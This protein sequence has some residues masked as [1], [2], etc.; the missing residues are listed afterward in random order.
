[1][2][3]I[4]LNLIC[5]LGIIFLIYLLIYSITNLSI[6]LTIFTI[7]GFIYFSSLSFYLTLHIIRPLFTY[8]YIFEDGIKIRRKDS[9][10]VNL[11]R[12]FCL[13]SEITYIKILKLTEFRKKGYFLQITFLNGISRKLNKYEVREPEEVFNIIAPKIKNNLNRS[14]RLDLEVFSEKSLDVY[15]PTLEFVEPYLQTDERI[16][17]DQIKLVNLTVSRILV[18]SITILLI[19]LMGFLYLITIFID[20]DQIIIIS[21]IITL[22][23]TGMFIIITFYSRKILVSRKQ[24]LHLTGAE[25]KNIVHFDTIANQRYIRRNFYSDIELYNENFHIQGLVTKDHLL[26]IPF[27][28]VERVIIDDFYHRIVFI[29]KHIKNDIEMDVQNVQNDFEFLNLSFSPYDLNEWD[30]L[31]KIIREIIPQN[32]IE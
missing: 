18:I 17:W 25:L 11:K 3:L 30:N 9:R 6:L 13:Y 32:K 28:R 31:V 2:I 29:I 15:F 19:L 14:N 20:I 23:F 21:C 10:K 24:G 12:K 8:L 26:F 27:N 16:L 5:I 7:F 4:L 22:L 1:M